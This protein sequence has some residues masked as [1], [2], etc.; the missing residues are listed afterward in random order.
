M[1]AIRVRVPRR[2]AWGGGRGLRACEGDI[3]PYSTTISVYRA[4]AALGRGFRLASA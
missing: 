2:R 4:R 1:R 3:I